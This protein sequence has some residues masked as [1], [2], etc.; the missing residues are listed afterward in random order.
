[1]NCITHQSPEDLRHIKRELAQETKCHHWTTVNSQCPNHKRKGR[2]SLQEPS[3][4][5]IRG[6]VRHLSFPWL[7]WTTS[8]LKQYNLLLW[9]TLEKE[10]P[11][12]SQLRETNPND[13]T[14]KGKDIHSESWE[15]EVLVC[16][17]EVEHLPSVQE[18][19]SAIPNTQNIRIVQIVL[20]NE[21]NMK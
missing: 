21:P 11:S 5:G 6:L 7:L 4:D 8:R 18:A 15:L 17:S 12:R 14:S 20:S 13:F 1:M 16:S 2:Q 19:L 9:G 3:S 10:A